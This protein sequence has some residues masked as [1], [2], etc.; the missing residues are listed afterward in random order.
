MKAAVVRTPDGECEITDISISEPAP[1]QVRVRISAA[2]VCRSDLSIANG[3]IPHRLPAVLGHEGAGTVV[4]AGSEVTGVAVGD[5]V[6]LNWMPACGTCGYCVRQQPYLCGVA[7]AAGSAD[8]ARTGDGTVL[9]AALGTGAFAEEVVLPARAVVPVGDGI[10]PEQAALLGCTVLTGYGAVRHTAAVRPGETVVV[11]GTGGVGQAVL[12]AARLAGAGAVFAVDTDPAKEESALA[13]GATHFHAD[14]T[15]ALRTVLK[16][17]GGMGA[18]HVLD[19]VGA[20]ETL[21]L[22]WKFTRRGGVTTVVGIGGRSQTV[23]FNVQD[24][25]TSGRT[26][27]GCVYG[28]SDPARDIP[29]LAE[30]VRAGRLDLGSLIGARIQLAD[31]PEVFRAGGFAGPG[32]A[33]VTME[34]AA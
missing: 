33:V 28:N 21:R 1:D 25:C 30:H 17:T 10:P 22:A 14:R 7:S 13:H 16:E 12:Q 15:G 11:L 20:P 26:L 19:C 29:L 6:V 27:R 32:R 8:Y 2:G 4:A 34:A 9:A 24:L 31:L 5:T 3:T 18:D 23:E